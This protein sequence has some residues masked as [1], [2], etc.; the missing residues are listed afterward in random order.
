MATI[1]AEAGVGIGTLYRHYPTRAALLGALTMKSFDVVLEQARLAAGST[2]PAPRVVARFLEQTI[3][4]RDRFILPFHGGPDIQ[5]E[6]ILAVRA[7]IRSL[8]AE[9]LN[10]GRQEGSIR[11]DVTPLDIIITG[12]M[13]AQPLP[14]VP[15]WDELARRQAQTFVAGISS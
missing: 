13:L 10:R 14:N 2:D 1:A 11:P 4:A 5:E 6:E 7:E 3:A 9:V 12:A 8:L 15:N